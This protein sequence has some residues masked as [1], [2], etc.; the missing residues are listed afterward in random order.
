M[1]RRVLAVLLAALVLTGCG[2]KQN[3][4]PDEPAFAPEQLPVT[5]EPDPG[6]EE[7]GEKGYYFGDEPVQEP[8]GDPREEAVEKLM[9]SMSLEEKV[10]QMFFVRCPELRAEEKDRKSVV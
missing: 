7:Q 1:R 2:G 6:L 8:E 9:E 5:V 10:G 4:A 3:D